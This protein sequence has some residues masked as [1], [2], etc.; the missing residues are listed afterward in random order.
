[1]TPLPSKT[2][3]VRAS[4]LCALCVAPAGV[5]TPRAAHAQP[6][7]DARAELLARRRA[8]AGV[9][10]SAPLAHAAHAAYVAPA[11]HKKSSP[12]PSAAPSRRGRATR[13]PAAASRPPVPTTLH[14]AS[15]QLTPSRSSS[16]A[17]TRVALTPASL[18]P[19]VAPTPATAATKSAATP[20][21][22]P[23]I[24]AAIA[25][26]AG[27]LKLG[28]LL[29]ALY[30]SGAPNARGT[31]RLRRA[32]LKLAGDVGERVAWTVMFDAAKALGVSPTY[33]TVDGQQVVS[34]TSVN[35]ASQ[36]LQDAFVAVRLPHG[37]AVEAGQMRVPL[38]LAGTLPGSKLEF[39]ERPM[40]ASDRARGGALGD[41]RDVGAQV[42]GTLLHRVDVV[43]GLFNGSG[44]SQ[45]A[46]DGDG[47]KAL[48]S[49]VVVRGLG[50]AGLQL[51]ASGAYG[52]PPTSAF[53]R[54]DRLG[55][56]AQF[57]ARGLTL[58]TEYMS[59]VDGAVR[60]AGYYGH[61]GVRVRTN[62]ELV[63]R[64]DVF[65]PDR[66]REGTT[67]TA[68]ARAILGGVDVALA[69]QNAALQLA[70]GTRA[71]RGAVAPASHQLLVSVQTSW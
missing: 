30:V 15:L 46:V 33:T 29:Q 16:A 62:V 70:Y 55:A 51:G 3:S 12:T 19:H 48:A 53:A 20:A 23:V 7:A 50:V 52:G 65:D 9:T 11:A 40:Y 5:A 42:R 60:R 56:E 22:L 43:A 17:M 4:L 1:M 61:A 21:A 8:A 6:R 54:R 39:V 13:A 45:N 18:P 44:E 41:V 27:T 71:Y 67:A 26:G 34:Q 37:F 47:E 36:M 69:G 14:T 59:G 35:A 49:R 64:V 63:G 57:T 25:P 10:A 28:G 2:T 24:P 31:F 32:E 66:A 58:R 38:G 68:R